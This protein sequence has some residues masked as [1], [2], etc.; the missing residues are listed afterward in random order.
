MDG[1]ISG[2]VQKG[3]VGMGGGRCEGGEDSLS[4]LLL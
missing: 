2:W 3:E 1:W 4:E